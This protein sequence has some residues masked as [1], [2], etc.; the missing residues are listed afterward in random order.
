MR[1]FRRKWIVT[2]VVVLVGIGLAIIVSRYF[3]P[4]RPSK[5]EAVAAHKPEAPPD[6]QQLRDRYLAG[7]AAIHD[8]DGVKAANTFASFSFGGR[9]VEEYRL[10][11]LGR[12]YELADVR[13]AAR[14]A[15]AE[16]WQRQPRAVIADDV[17]Q[18][19][20]A[21]Y[22]EAGDFADAAEVYDELAERTV[23]PN[24]AAAARWGAIESHFIDGDIDSVLD[25][26]RTTAIK[27]P[28]A[29]QAVE[30][31]AVVR[32]ISG[33]PPDGTI[34]MTPAERLERAVALMRDGDPQSA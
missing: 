9:A 31:L 3:R 30:A 22:A 16:L 11:H 14:G 28:R 24:T 12:A 25:A 21:L 18:R 32:S 1:A 20:A 7:L 34:E 10:Y 6:L 29:P 33:L 5:E 15:Y 23:A 19:L 4:R 13:G 2:T 17:A 8:K 26:A 27:S